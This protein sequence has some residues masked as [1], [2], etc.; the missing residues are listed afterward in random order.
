MHAQPYRERRTVE[1]SQGSCIVTTELRR[2]CLHAA[3]DKADGVSR[4]VRWNRGSNFR[5]Y[6]W[7]HLCRTCK[8]VFFVNP[9]D[10]YKQQSKTITEEFL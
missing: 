4:Q 10:C 7:A 8:D 6:V 5:P 2:V 9:A 3:N 1:S